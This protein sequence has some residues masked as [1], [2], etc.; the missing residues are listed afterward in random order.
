MRDLLDQIRIVS[1]DMNGQ[2]V[3]NTLLGL[4]GVRMRW[5][6]L[7]LSVREALYEAVLRTSELVVITCNMHT[8]TH[9]LIYTHIH[10]YLYITYEKIYTNICRCHLKLLEIVSMP[11]G[12]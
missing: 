11:W 2:A 10:S 7:P 3:S 12:S 8:Y 1:L 5:Q 4:Y 9:V 6:S